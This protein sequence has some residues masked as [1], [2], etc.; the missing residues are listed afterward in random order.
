[1]TVPASATAPRD[2]RKL[3]FEDS[4][5]I[6]LTNTRM[7]VIMRMTTIRQPLGLTL[8]EMEVLLTS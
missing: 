7:R 2:K 3:L 4:V 6:P 1:M 8:W 5:R